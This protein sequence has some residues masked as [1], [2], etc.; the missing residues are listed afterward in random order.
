M[1]RN[2]WIWVLAAVFLAC[3]VQA[4]QAQD[5]APATSSSS[6]KQDFIQAADVLLSVIGEPPRADLPKADDPIVHRFILQAQNLTR[7]LGTREMPVTQ[8]ED[9]DVLCR[10]G[11]QI[12][13]AYM[14]AGLSDRASE[15]NSAASG[16]RIMQQVMAENTK[17][18]FDI[19]LPLTLYELHCQAVQMPPLEG[20]ASNSSRKL[21]GA[22]MDYLYQLRKGAIQMIVGSLIMTSD[23]RLTQDRHAILSQLET[24]WDG[25]VLPLS[26]EERTQL[27]AEMGRLSNSMATDAA[28]SKQ[29]KSLGERIANVK[30]GALCAASDRADT[31]DGH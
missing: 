12:Q 15:S 29:I 24:D 21:A 30:C 8:V 16:T 26:V 2:V 4:S 18:Y 28:A 11:A 10:K 19:F 13:T 17:K 23:L 1:V 25:L 3:G 20:V 31:N 14:L 6:S 22:G 7:L 9:I 27:A 5:D